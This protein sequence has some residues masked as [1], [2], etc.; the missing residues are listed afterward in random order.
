MLHELKSWPE[1]YGAAVSG[2]KRFEVRLNDRG[3]RVADELLLREYDP[4]REEYTGRSAQFL[5]TYILDSVNDVIPRGISP[6]YVV[7][8]IAPLDA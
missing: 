3:F 8:S 5:V 6:D 1:F 7:M 4:E 2:E